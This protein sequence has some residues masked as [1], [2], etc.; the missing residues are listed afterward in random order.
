MHS[1][2]PSTLIYGQCTPGWKALRLIIEIGDLDDVHSHT[3]HLD[4]LV[5]RVEALLAQTHDLTIFLTIWP[6]ASVG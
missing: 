3:V 5:G 4:V 2:L 1:G 6:E